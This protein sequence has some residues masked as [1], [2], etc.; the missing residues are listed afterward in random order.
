MYPLLTSTRKD[1]VNQS[2]VI[3]IGV[4]SVYRKAARDPDRP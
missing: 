4:D 3:L 1:F 2:G